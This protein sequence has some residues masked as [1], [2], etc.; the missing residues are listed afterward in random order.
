MDSANLTLSRLIKAIL[1]AGKQNHPRRR[2]LLNKKQKNSTLKSLILELMIKEMLMN[3]TSAATETL[4][5]KLSQRLL[6]R[7][8]SHNKILSVT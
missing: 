7:L 6:H 4:S 2:P 8:S 1:V 3:L 5:L